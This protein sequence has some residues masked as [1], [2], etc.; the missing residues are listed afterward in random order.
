MLLDHLHLNLRQKPCGHIASAKDS[1]ASSDINQLMEDAQNQ[2]PLDIADILTRRQ[3]STTIGMNGLN[4]SKGHS[5]IIHNS[6]FLGISIAVSVLHSFLEF[7]A[8]KVM[9]LFRILKD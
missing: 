3:M 2:S 6:Y 5:L 9:F 8:F 7:L 1:L 4:N